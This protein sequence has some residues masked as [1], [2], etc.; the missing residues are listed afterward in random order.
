MIDGIA[1]SLPVWNG[2]KTIKKLLESIINQSYRNIKIFIIDNRSTDKT[3]SIIKKI[4]KKDNRVKLIL[5]TKRRSAAEAQ[6]IIFK[7]YI[8]NYKYYMQVGDDDIYHRDFFKT[9]INKLKKEKTG[10]VYS[11]YKLIDARNN[12]YNIR[13]FPTYQLQKKA[14]F[15]PYFINLIK[16]I[17]YRNLIPM[18]IGIFVAKEFA[19]S[20]KYNKVY[21]KS[22]VNYDNL[23]LIHFLTNN[24]VSYIKKKLIY[25]RKK[26]RI[27]VALNRTQKSIYQ[28]QNFSF[29]S[30]K[31]FIYQFTFSKKVINIINKSKKINLMHKILLIQFMI[32][33]Y[34]QK[35][36]SFIIKKILKKKFQFD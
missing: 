8:K 22:E 36:F 20:F 11:S 1:I 14:K 30:F 4:Q 15:N 35:S 13:D 5:D 19:K 24:Q 28:F 16:F 34:F 27:K 17:L 2:E 29:T 21:D 12:L 7:K 10:L 23:Y 31:I 33:L 18:V 25:Y 26:D 32:V 3:V 6:K 9:A